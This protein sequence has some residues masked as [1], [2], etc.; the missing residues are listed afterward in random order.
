M[1][2]AFLFSI[3]LVLVTVI[4]LVSALIVLNKVREPLKE[5]IGERQF[6]LISLYQKGE[7][8]KFFIEQAAKIAARETAII[9]A[10]SGGFATDGKC[11]DYISYNLWNQGCFPDYETEFR[12]LFNVQFGKHLLAYG[13]LPVDYFSSVT[14]EEPLTVVSN[15]NSPIVL[16]IQ[17]QLVAPPTKPQ[18][19]PIT[20]V[21]QVIAKNEKNLI[22]NIYSLY[23][24]II[25]NARLNYPTVDEAL[26]AGTI[27]QESAGN[28]SAISPTGCA[29]LMQF[30]YATAKAYFNQVTACD[31]T[32][33]RQCELNHAC[34]ANNDD[35][36]S[37][38]SSINAGVKYYSE[39]LAQFSQY[40]DRIRFAI[41]AYNSG[42]QVVRN[43]IK[44]TGISDPTWEEVAASLRP[45][46]IPYF[47]TE[48]QKLGQIAQV[49]NHVPAV[50]KYMNE[51][52]LLTYDIMQQGLTNLKSI[53]TQK[54][55]DCCVCQTKCGIDCRLE[56]IPES[57]SCGFWSTGQGI[58][59]GLDYC[60]APSQLAGAYQFTPSITTTI[61]YSLNDYREIKAT[62]DTAVLQQSDIQRTVAQLNARNPNFKWSAEL[63]CDSAEEKVFNSF[64]EGFQLCAESEDTDCV[65]TFSMDF[66][67]ANPRDGA[68][69]IKITGTRTSFELS[70]ANLDY[71]VPFDAYFVPR[72][73]VARLNR[74]QTMFPNMVLDKPEQKAI[75][76]AKYITYSVKY[77]GGSFSK[78]SLTIPDSSE[79][80]WALAM[81]AGEQ[82]GA[83]RIYENAQG[84]LAFLSEDDYQNSQ[85]PYQNKSACRTTKEIYRLCVTKLK[86]SNPQQFLIINPVNSQPDLQDLTYR[87]AVTLS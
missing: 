85:L 44:A 22:Q 52:K 34:N 24:Q 49:R 36:F 1:K 32:G 39:L 80:Q 82:K 20:Q 46:H 14:S 68:F 23:G 9:L 5:K 57:Q 28:P 21:P 60:A 75:A 81:Y 76:A 70:A 33:K 40:T 51:Y 43:A 74:I 62:L 66:G 8:I 72:K 59:C 61:D 65:C 18:S 53:S 7:S 79:S 37:A 86:D 84:D 6:Q 26:I 45:A 50:V 48:A 71:S 83:V 77:E 2:K 78:A 35:R 56:A 11:S 16:D 25:R 10:K 63:D 31:C 30:C 15:A 38:E 13:E 55:H 42:P 19:Q 69:E 47:S 17:R 67:R 58:N 3:S 64:V 27:A 4:V 87:F 41:A 54:T 29:G 12:N 73:T